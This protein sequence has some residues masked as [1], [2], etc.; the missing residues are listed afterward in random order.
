MNYMPAEEKDLSPAQKR[1]LL[2]DILD[3]RAPAS[4]LYPLSLAQKRLWFLEQ[5]EPRMALYQISSGLRFTGDLDPHVL[6]SA[7]ATILERHETLRTAFL[8]REGEVF[9]SISPGV[10]VEI[11]MID[12]EALPDS[13]RER[14][15]YQIACAEALRPFDLQSS[16]LVRLKLI[17]MAS[18]HHILLFTM[19]HLVSDSWSFG[20]FVEELAELYESQMEGRPSRLAPLAVQY[21][22]FTRWQGKS[23]AGDELDRQAQ[24]WKTKLAGIPALIELPTDRVRPVEQCFTC[25]SVSVPLPS[26]VVEALKALGHQEGTTLFCV[27]LAALNTLL[28][29]Y[30]SQEDVCVGVPVAGRGQVETEGLIG[31]FVNTLVIR[32]D[33]SGNPRF[34]DLLAQVRESLLDAHSNQDVPFEKVVEEIQPKRSLAYNPLFQVM[35]TAVKDPQCVRRFGSLMAKPYPVA[36]ATSSL[37]LTA[38]VIEAVDGTLWWR[39]EYNT[40]LFDSSRIQRMLSHYLKLLDSITENP[41]RRI[42]DLD[43]IPSAELAQFST[44]N[45]NA[46]PYPRACLHTLVAG[47]AAR[48][49]DAVA[50]VF[51]ERHLTYAALNHR[52]QQV[53][54][55]LHAAGARAGSRVAVCLERSLE[56][57]AGV[58]GVLQ[59]GAAYV[60]IDPSQP[61]ERVSMMM[62]DAGVE[63][64]L[65]QRHLA[66]RLSTCIAARVL[67][68]DTITTAPCA[69]QAEDDPESL[70]YIMFTSGSTGRP[71]G[72]AVPH[73]A[74]VNLLSS[75][76]RV[77]GLAPHD[78]FLAVTNLSFDISVLELFG[79]LITGARTVIASKEAQTDGAKLLKSLQLHGITMMQATPVTWR[80]L[81]AAGWTRET[82]DCKV[83]CGGEA[84]PEDLA[85][86]L[87]ERSDSV[88][89]L[90]GPT[91]TTIWSSLSR[92]KRHCPV[93]IGRPVQNTQFY[94]LDRRMRPVPTGVSGELYIGGDGLAAGYWNRA[95]LKGDG[96]FQNPFDPAAGRVYKTGDRVRWRADGELEYLGRV[97][98]QV[99]V[100]G[101]RIEL[102][103]VEAVVKQHAGIE[104]AVAIVRQDL[105]GDQRLVCYVV[106]GEG[107]R[108]D[109]AAIRASVKNKLPD[110]M[111]PI[112]VLLEA[113]PLTSNGK[114]DR[115]LLPAPHE[116]RRRREKPRNTFEKRL[117]PIWQQVLGVDRIGI[118]D[119]FF[120]LGGHSLL[121]M[122][123]LAEIERV[124]D[125]RLPMATIFAAQT[126]EE[127]AQV[128]G[129]SA[130]QP[131]S[132]LLAIRKQGS[133]PP[134]FIVPMA[135]GNPLAYASLARFLG[136]DQPV[137]VFQYAGLEGDGSPMERVEKIAEYF[138]AELRKIQPRGPYRFAGFCL[139][140]IVAYEMA[141]QLVARG[142]EAPHLALVETWHP[143]SI[144][145]TRGAPA[146]VRPLLFFARAMGRHLGEM[147]KLP[148]S[149]GIR[150]FR[151]KGVL[152]RE[153]LFY[154]D[155]YRGDRRKRYRDSVFE[156][157]YRAGSRYLPA[158]YAG[159]AHLFLANDKF[160]ET[161]ADTRLVWRELI[162]NCIVVPNPVGDSMDLLQKPYVQVFADRLAQWMW[163]S[164]MAAVE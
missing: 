130:V 14:E 58:L 122:R 92:V 109:A 153:M 6:R 52:A 148:V 89:N 156:A 61:V 108:I 64:L 119:N 152:L 23:L 34:R 98:L 94:V 65:T 121:A 4:G 8:L 16:P 90:Y 7:V 97:D 126:L 131:V 68:E 9:Q 105:P 13:L 159:S 54:A 91:E 93:T 78:R 63:L 151:E 138:L 30:T 55:A 5:L 3:R 115:A 75:M 73:R 29:R 132:S 95:E 70:A 43:L 135:D 116:D 134:L 66:A 57:V 125:R 85:N 47:Q 32:T 88:W 11:P 158:P 49:P 76:Q 25:G 82:G 38:F 28:L 141:Q 157:N 81:I 127:M 77:P 46:A 162:E 67:I 144:R 136:S 79:P 1:R 102:G 103:E 139:G 10:D 42:G 160:V 143:S 26:A 51:E 40:A 48:S 31:L 145:P 154:R 12:L 112:L 106:P 100:R 36:I 150:Y 17:K 114:I 110:Y 19:H 53:A 60:P 118:K 35:M 62:E 101:L 21:S 107:V 56:M 20:V 99:K 117:L 163:E 15:A 22:D 80:L 59:T 128:L 72:V 149:Q 161:V 2:A 87:L 86:Q 74:V 71:K 111:V 124:F 113:L 120:D 45:D 44:W 27:L 39:L 33:M 37:D 24:Y 69:S 155:V 129:Q 84:L 140:G 41:D 137:Y 104:Q 123:L 96:F 146:A 142:E 147:V 18:H 50:A 133:Q 83:L 164:Y